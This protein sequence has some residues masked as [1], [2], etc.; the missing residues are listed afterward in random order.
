MNMILSN[1]DFLVIQQCIEH[2]FTTFANVKENCERVYT[3]TKGHC[4][5][6]SIICEKYSYLYKSAPLTNSYLHLVHF[7]EDAVNNAFSK[8]MEQKCK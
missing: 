7:G 4:N 8:L 2:I 1:D 3:T 6:F 5:V